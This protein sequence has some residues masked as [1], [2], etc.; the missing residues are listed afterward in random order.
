MDL[1]NTTLDI[2]ADEIIYLEEKSFLKTI[3]A[4]YFA[5]ACK[6]SHPCNESVQIGT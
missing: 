2:W 3:D 5:T 6:I 4:K 1:R